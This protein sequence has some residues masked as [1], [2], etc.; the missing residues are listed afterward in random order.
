M[1]GNTSK[2]NHALEP[3]TRATKIFAPS[4]FMKKL[5][6]GTAE[7]RV[8]VSELF[9]SGIREFAEV[10]SLQAVRQ[11]LYRPSPTGQQHGSANS[12]DGLRSAERRQGFTR[13][14][15]PGRCRIPKASLKAVG[16]FKRSSVLPNKEG[17]T[18]NPPPTLQC[19]NM[20]EWKH[21]SREAAP[22]L[23]FRT[24]SACSTV[25]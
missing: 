8:A 3:P 10:Y 13:F 19:Q 4:F 12:G 15:R 17:L 24:W 11:D 20:L 7:N 9:S 25:A 18:P 14:A 1:T 23:D 16:T 22:L 2:E 6:V 5:L 21:K